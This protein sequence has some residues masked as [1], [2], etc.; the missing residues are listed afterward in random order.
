MKKTLIIAFLALGAAQAASIILPKIRPAKEEFPQMVELPEVVISGITL[1]TRGYTTE[2]SVN[3]VIEPCPRNNPLAK[4]DDAFAYNTNAEG[5][6]VY[7]T[8]CRKCNTG[9]YSEHQGETVRTC[10]FCKE[11]EGN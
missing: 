1:G 9:V 11:P 5:A 7:V 2:V 4:V 10:T 6:V 8:H 3:V